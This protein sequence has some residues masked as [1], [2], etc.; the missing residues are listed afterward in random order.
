MGSKRKIHEEWLV[1]RCQLGEAEAY[2]ELVTMIEKRLF[3]Y[4]RMLVSRET[5]AYDILQE[6]WLTV[7]K[8]IRKLRDPKAFHTWIYRIAHDLAVSFIRQEIRHEKIQESYAEEALTQNDEPLL[9]L[10]DMIQV[11]HALNR[12]NPLHRE[13][14]ALYFVEDMSYEEIAQVAGCNLGTVKSR[15]H[16][17]KKELR[18]VLEARNGEKK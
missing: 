14:L 3:Y 11:H 12:L 9:E 5:D 1:L 10:E 18:H 4:I 16:Y 2:R 15:M 8:K 7:F 17:A 13:V 6:V